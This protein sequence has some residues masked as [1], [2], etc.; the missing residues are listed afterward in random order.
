MGADREG[1]ASEIG[2]V[3]QRE[4]REIPLHVTP[5]LSSRPTEQVAAEANEDA[6]KLEEQ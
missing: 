2:E 4:V 5:R 3:A 6:H 1:S